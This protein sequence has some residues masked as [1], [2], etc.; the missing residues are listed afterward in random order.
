MIP[1]DSV[2]LGVDVGGTKVAAGLVTSRGEILSKVRVPM[3]SRE[4]G[5]AGL[6]AVE[7]AID[8]AFAAAPARKDSV[9]GIGIISPGPVDPL[10]GLVVNP[11][12]LP[13]W[14]NYP[15]VAEITKSRGLPTVLDNDANAAALAEAQWGAA[16]GYSSVFYVTIGT[17]IGTGIVLNGSIYHGRTGAAGEG[18][19]VSIDYH[20]P[21]CP[22][23]KRGCI[24]VLTA[25]P[26]VARRARARLEAG[27]VETTT[28]LTLAGGNPLAVT[29]ELV[30]TAWRDGD[31]LATTILEETS[32]LLA[33]WLGNMIDLFDPEVIVVGGGMS[34]LI[35]GWSGRIRQQ[36]PKWT[37]NSRCGETPFVRAQY[38]EDSGIVGA[39]ALCASVKAT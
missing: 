39:A 3:M 6:R 20:G 25:G 16:A 9:A 32:D 36:I 13:C 34:E 15:L 17:G 38:G 28:L 7:K 8:A 29:A 30:A 23:G 22:C 33:I 35:V 31:P 5:A 4:D 14:R 37:V 11:G 27:G 24:E 21:L 1:H 26:A 19:H 10:Q 12:N 2:Y 18:G